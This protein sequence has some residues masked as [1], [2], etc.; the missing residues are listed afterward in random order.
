MKLDPV[1]WIVPEFWMLKG[2]MVPDPTSW[3]LFIWRV[4]PPPNVD[5]PNPSFIV[6]TS[7]AITRVALADDSE[8]SSIVSLEFSVTV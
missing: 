8:R 7:L 5:T 4:L 3:P 6:R 1:D 2:V